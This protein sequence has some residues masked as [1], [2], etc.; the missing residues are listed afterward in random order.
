[1]FKLSVTFFI[2]AIISAVLGFSELIAYPNISRIAFFI[3]L[4]L[5]VLTMLAHDER[6]YKYKS[7]HCVIFNTILVNGRTITGRYFYKGNKPEHEIRAEIITAL[8]KEKYLLAEDSFIKL[9]HLTHINLNEASWRTLNLGP[10]ASTALFV[11]RIS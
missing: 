11:D 8:Y 5:F 6:I 4:C 9:T 10:T 7:K 3:F 2:L 1:M